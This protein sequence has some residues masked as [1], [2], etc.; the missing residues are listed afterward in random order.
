MGRCLFRDQLKQL[1]TSVLF[2]LLLMVACSVQEDA[3][4]SSSSSTAATIEA[5]TPAETTGSATTTLAPGSSTSTTSFM[6]WVLS[7]ETWPPITG[8]GDFSDVDIVDLDHYLINELIVQ[9]AHDHGIPVNL[10]PAGDG[11]L[12]ENVPV[13]QSRQASEIVAGCRNGLN[14]P[15]GDGPYFGYTLEQAQRVYDHYL[16]VADCLTEA[17]YPPPDPPSFDF[18][19]E[20]QTWHPYNNGVAPTLARQCPSFPAGRTDG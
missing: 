9:C 10:D 17:G 19:L 3:V 20:T 15:I 6:D 5:T 2:S 18:W 12:F 16:W 14:I 8:Y 7:L 1:A 4:E 11:I 13:E